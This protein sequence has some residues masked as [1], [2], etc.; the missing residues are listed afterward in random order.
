MAPCDTV[1][2]LLLPDGGLPSQDLDA[3]RHIWGSL[4]LRNRTLL[5]ELRV[6]L[7]LGP[8]DSPVRA[9]AARELED[10]LDVPVL[11]VCADS[12]AR[13][14]N[15]AFQFAVACDGARFWLHLDDEHA[16][17]RAFWHAARAV[18]AAPGRHLW[19][20]QLS[21]DWSDLSS[22]RSVAC[23]G[24][25]QI[26]PHP[27]RAAQAALDPEAYEDEE[28]FVSH[29]PLFSLRPAVHALEHFREAVQ[30]GLLPL[31]PFD[32]GASWA[33]LQWRFGLR[34]QELGAPK[35]VLTPAGFEGLGP[36]EDPEDESEETDPPD[37]A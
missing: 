19:Q 27:D 22:E 12:W 25:T 9:A 2:T 32:E 18:L 16:C 28:P 7:L 5:G 24:F 4:I 6:V 11:H 8:E 33:A 30:R 20:L 26:L 13:C 36:A 17:T 10:A 15:E 21:D 23:D 3:F 29:W 34:L 37:E 35:G 14:F 31:K 1:L